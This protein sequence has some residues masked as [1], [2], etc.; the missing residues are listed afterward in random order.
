M[1]ILTIYEEHFKN[2][3]GIVAAGTQLLWIFEIF[4]FHLRCGVRNFL[5]E[6]NF[7]EFNLERTGTLI[8]VV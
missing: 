6:N 7:N 2:T 8:P 1:L 5:S 4:P 3:K